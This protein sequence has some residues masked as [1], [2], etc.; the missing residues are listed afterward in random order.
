VTGDIG[1]RG[2]VILRFDPATSELWAGGVGL[3]KTRQ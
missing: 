2:P 3:F 1:Y